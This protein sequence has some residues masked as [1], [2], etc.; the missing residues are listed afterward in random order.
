MVAVAPVPKAVPFVFVQTIAFDPLVAQ[1]PL[2]SAPVMALALP[3][4]NPVKVL[5]VPVPP[6]AT[7]IVLPFHVP[8]VIVP[9]ELSGRNAD[10]SDVHVGAALALTAVTA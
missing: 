6:Y 2:S 9:M 4:T 1:S 8:P 5:P 3:R 10:V 7:P